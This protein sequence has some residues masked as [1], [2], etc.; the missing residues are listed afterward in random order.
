MYTNHTSLA[1]LDSGQY[2]GTHVTDAHWLHA[3][4]GAPEWFVGSKRV[5]I[6]WERTLPTG[7]KLTDTKYERLLAVSKRVYF[8]SRGSVLIRPISETTHV[9]L[10]E[11]LFGLID[12]ITY[13]EDIFHSTIS[14]FSALDR[15]SVKD[16]LTQYVDGGYD[17]V[18]FVILRL[19]QHFHM[20]CN[21]ADLTSSLVLSRLTIPSRVY[22]RNLDDRVDYS[23]S[24]DDIDIIRSW[25][26]LNG[27]YIRNGNHSE[28]KKQKDGYLNRHRIGELL[29]IYRYSA[30]A[31]VSMF[32][33]QFE[34]VHNYQIVEQFSRYPH[35]EQIP[36]DYE[37]DELQ[38]HRKKSARSVCAFQQLFTNF[39]LQSPY[40]DGLPRLE[41]LNAL[42][43]ESVASNA[44]ARPALHTRTM[45]TDIALH[46]LNS[47]IGYIHKYGDALITYVE[48]WTAN[49]Q[50]MQ[51]DSDETRKLLKQKAFTNT[52]RPAALK[53]LN[54]DALY[55]RWQLC[56]PCNGNGGHTAAARAREVFGLED[57]I[58]MLIVSV[59]VLV[60]V[61]SARRRGEMIDLDCNCSSGDP[62]D[63]ELRF[64]LEKSVVEGIRRSI[65]RPIPN[66]AAKG[67]DMLRRLSTIW[68]SFVGDESNTRLFYFPVMLARGLPATYAG[69]QIHLDRFSDYFEVPLNEDGRRWYVKPHEFRRFFAIVFFWQYKYSNL[70]ALQWMLGHEKPEDTYAY[71]RSVVGGREMTRQ[72]ARFSR[73][74]M[75]DECSEPAVEQL[76][77]LALKHFQTTDISLIAEEDL[78]EYLEGLIDEGVYRVRPHGIQTAEG[79]NYDMVFEIKKD[80]A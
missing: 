12:W 45:P 7:S 39:A 30:S 54:I 74:V 3:D 42:S 43:I 69:I 37:G 27:Y 21:T 1:F 50:D 58:N 13:Q 17:A 65:T 73:E 8:D 24:N 59:Y 33:R 10:A 72:E 64:L 36:V 57:A 53:P 71:V 56:V 46:I 51:S 2:P 28:A 35:R 4:Y 63:H 79:T 60:A 68:M 78:V 15:N 67:V 19:Q 38:A 52:A 66:I 18:R 5:R 32:L 20:L 75:L 40:L 62:G 9:H 44:G 29:G 34:Y 11:K 14:A 16:F 47:A 23:Y 70:T 22:A 61:M 41:E 26:Y 80:C 6:N 76:K 49:V 48:A 55:S 31:T 25:L 77:R